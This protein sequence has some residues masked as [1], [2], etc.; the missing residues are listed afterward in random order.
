MKNNRKTFKITH[1][2]ITSTYYVD[3]EKITK[4]L[5]RELEKIIIFDEDI[6]DK[7]I[8]KEVKSS[9]YKHIR[10]KGESWT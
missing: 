10:E 3:I 1:G 7:E 9:V 2:D 8:V 4:R 5:D 6:E